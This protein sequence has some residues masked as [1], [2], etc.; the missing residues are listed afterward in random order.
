MEKV[1]PKGSNK[2]TGSRSKS[3]QHLHIIFTL[4]NKRIC[5]LF[6]SDG[7]FFNVRQPRLGKVLTFDATIFCETLTRYLLSH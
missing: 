2:R 6:H 7:A 1:A 4:L 3:N 5:H